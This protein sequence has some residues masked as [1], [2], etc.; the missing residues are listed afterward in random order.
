MLPENWKSEIQEAIDKAAR[1][2]DEANQRASEIQTKI[3]ASVDAIADAFSK[4]NEKHYREDS[5][6]RSRET[7]TL[8]ALGAAA[9]FTLGLD[10]LSGCQLHEMQKAYG[11]IK[12]SAKAA[13]QSADVAEKALVSTQRAFIRA[14]NFP[15]LWRPD[16]DR[17]GK[18]FY[19]ITP[20][21][22][23]AG[24]TPTKDL[25]LVVDSALR[26]TPL[27]DDFTFPYRA[28]PAP[29]L[30]GAHQ[31]VGVNNAIILDD[32]LLSVK[33]GKKFFYIWGTATYR[34]V[35]DETP[36][37]TTEF[38]TAIG[39]VIGDPLDPRDPNNP[40]GTSVEISF[41]IYPKHQKTD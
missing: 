35:F 34:D 27:P 17:P 28:I 40:K 30:V 4:Q 13:Q 24:N 38:C 18:Y 23:N 22:E 32:D 33:Q 9:I 37:H 39:R 10:V 29:S 8:C 36:E 6:K 1:G 21:L 14:S 41:N 15:W 3:S 31:T 16:L 19:D 20:I 26:E 12:D 7:W 25:M 5:S 2:T 11:P